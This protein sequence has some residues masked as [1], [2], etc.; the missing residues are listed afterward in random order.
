MTLIAN[1]LV[2]LAALA[3]AGL[4]WSVLPANVPRGPDRGMYGLVCLMFQVPQALLLTLALLACVARSAPWPAAGGFQYLL[5]LA[6][7]A[8]LFFAAFLCVVAY[9]DGFRGGDW[10]WLSTALIVVPFALAAAEIA[11]VL[12]VMNA[13]PR[14]RGGW[15][16]LASVAAIS[17]VALA[18]VYLETLRSDA[19]YSASLREDSKAAREGDEAAYATTLDRAFA[20][21]APG[22][23]LIDWLLFTSPGTQEAR[24]APALAA[25]ARR[26]DLARDFDRSLMVDDVNAEWQALMLVEQ[27]PSACVPPLLPTFQGYGRRLRQEIA[28]A[29]ADTDPQMRGSRLSAAATRVTAYLSAARGL[30]RAGVDVRPELT[31]IVVAAR[32]T[33]EDASRQIVKQCEACLNSLSFEA[34]AK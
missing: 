9:L 11:F 29:A 28:A 13:S 32:I 3:T 20:K 14:A 12:F 19:R 2:F 30:D 22:D 25:I 8:A 34:G 17:A 23:P 1:I 27:L 31:A 7:Q 18:G 24:R 10:R 33:N 4:A 21:L 5:V 6:G 16:A 26:P 15:V